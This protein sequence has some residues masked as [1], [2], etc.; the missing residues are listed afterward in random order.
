MACADDG[1]LGLG[2]AELLE[3][4]I[5]AVV[6][7]QVQ[8]QEHHVVG[9]GL[10]LDELIA[11]LVVIVTSLSPMFRYSE[12]RSASGALSQPTGTRR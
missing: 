7:G 1:T 2:L 11:S 5:R 9:C 8:R 6:V 3:E 10:N 12:R 4:L